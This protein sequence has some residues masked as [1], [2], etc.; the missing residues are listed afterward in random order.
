MT[1]PGPAAPK[2]AT[3]AVRLW[4]AGGVLFILSAVIYFAFGD[5]RALPVGL[6]IISAAV[7]IGLVVLARR[8]S[9]GD[10]RWRSTVAVLTLTATVLGMLVAALTTVPFVLISG[11]VAIAGSML[12]YRPAAEPWFTRGGV[13]G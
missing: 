5:A 13:G 8:A 6:G 3:W 11:L 9:G 12:A 4:N 2:Q 10:A 1:T 7:G